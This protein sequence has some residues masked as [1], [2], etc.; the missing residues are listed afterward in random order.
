ML[1]VEE[2]QRKILEKVTRMPSEDSTTKDALRHILAQDIV[3]PVDIPPF[4]NSAVDGFAVRSQDTPGASRKSPVRLVMKGTIAAGDTPALSVS[5]GECIKVMTGAA[6]PAGA[7]SVVM[8]EDVRAEEDGVLIFAP[9]EKG[10][11]IRRMGEDIERSQVVLKEGSLLRPQE[12]GVLASL[13]MARVSVVARPLVALAATGDEL[14]GI[15]E[16]L[17]PGKIRDSNRYS[18]AGLI[19]ETGCV[20]LE[21]GIIPDRRQDMESAFR[22]ALGQSDVLITTGGVSMGEYD[23]VR[24]VLSS[25]G[26]IVFWQVNMKPGKPLTFAVAD[27]KPVFGLPGNPVSCMVSFEIFVRPALLAMMGHNTVFK[28]MVQARAVSDIE[29]KKG[30]AEFKRGRMS[31]QGGILFVDLTGP[32]G[33]GILTSMVKADGL[34]YLAEDRG[35]VSSGE[36]VSVIPL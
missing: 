9:A 31:R 1:S 34:V 16:P 13:G 11:N 3:S 35:P 33:S 8:I 28:D 18:L 29:K 14:V 5:R 7:D 26:E 15:E 19:T 32:Q 25:I 21:L 23:L 27:G 36:E 2:A 10:E 24:E 30:R 17:S 20:P 22:G 6:M 4:D 12:L